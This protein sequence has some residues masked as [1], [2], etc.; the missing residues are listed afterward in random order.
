MVT[1]VL[2]VVL[3]MLSWDGVASQQG[4]VTG[5][6]VVVSAG[7]DIILAC[8]PL[9]T[10]MP[11]VLGGT[12]PPVWYY[13]M[14]TADGYAKEQRQPAHV[15]GHSIA[16]TYTNN[17][18]H[19]FMKIPH[20]ST[21]INGDVFTCRSGGIIEAYI[22]MVT[23]TGWTCSLCWE[24]DEGTTLVVTCEMTRDAGARDLFMYSMVHKDRT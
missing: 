21:S 17:Q 24:A 12:A 11:S 14:R 18:T 5:T 8:P 7:T 16:I 10:Q 3:C 9:L 4:S 2:L 23:T 1:I 6:P 13:H 22:V 15:R 19:S 20:A